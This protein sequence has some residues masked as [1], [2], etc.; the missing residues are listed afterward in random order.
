MLLLLIYIFV[1]SFKLRSFSNR[2]CIDVN[3]AI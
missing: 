1:A 2:K 3:N